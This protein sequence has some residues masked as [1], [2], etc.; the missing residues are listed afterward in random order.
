MLAVRRLHHV[1]AS[2]DQIAVRTLQTGRNASTAHR[3]HCRERQ[4]RQGN[5]DDRN[6]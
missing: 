2:F 6:I 3:Q 1:R 4:I 5:I